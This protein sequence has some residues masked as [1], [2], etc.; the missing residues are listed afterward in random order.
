MRLEDFPLL[1]VGPDI[2]DD[3]R[4]VLI[5]VEIHI[6]YPQYKWFPEI[7]AN[8]SSSA[9]HLA[10]RLDDYIK[11]NGQ[12]SKFR[13]YIIEE[14]VQ[15]GLGITDASDEEAQLLIDSPALS[16][17]TFADMVSRRAQIG[18]STHGHSAVDVNIYGTKGTDALRGNH[19]NTDVG[20]FLRSYLDLDVQAITDELVKKLDTFA[21]SSDSGVGWTGR[22]PSEAELELAVDHYQLPI[23]ESS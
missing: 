14:L 7:L 1:D 17:Y 12:D 18:W 21:V 6:M 4:L 22:I 16:V 9:E 19:E 8:V 11:H 13:Q 15:K 23:R 5:Y 10:D 2:Q 20:K 3:L